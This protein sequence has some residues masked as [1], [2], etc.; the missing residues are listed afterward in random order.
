MRR[1]K[2]EEREEEEEKLSGETGVVISGALVPVLEPNITGLAILLLPHD[3][4][5]CRSLHDVRVS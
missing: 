4:S 1:R 2:K 3:E 5:D